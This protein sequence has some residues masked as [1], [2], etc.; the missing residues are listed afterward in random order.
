MLVLRNR[1]ASDGTTRLSTENPEVLAWF[2]KA[3]NAYRA[4][5]RL[6]IL[7]HK[8]NDAFPMPR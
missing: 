3:W 2:I 1:L 6:R 7:R 8:A 4:G 5:K